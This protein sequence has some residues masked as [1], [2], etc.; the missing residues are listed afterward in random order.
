MNMGKRHYSYIIRI[1]DIQWQS[2]LK[3][4]FYEYLQE[5]GAG[6]CYSEDGL[7]I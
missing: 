6:L 1:S 5:F 3:Y 7:G 2:Y 4:Y